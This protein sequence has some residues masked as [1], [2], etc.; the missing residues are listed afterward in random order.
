LSSIDNSASSS[1]G[2]TSTGSTAGISAIPG[3]I[4]HVST[5]SCIR[6]VSCSGS[7]GCCGGR[8]ISS[9]C[10]IASLICANRRSSNSNWSCIRDWIRCSILEGVDGTWGSASCHHREEDP[11]SNSLHSACGQ[12]SIRSPSNSN[13]ARTGS[14]KVEDNVR[15]VIGS[16]V[17]ENEV[18]VKGYH[19]CHIV[20]G[21][22]KAK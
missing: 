17:E 6:A 10:S 16:T 5:I 19:S 13:V 8:G 20:K 12:S 7:R 4:S 3:S 9:C 15:V 21:T 22:C 11:I 1:R 18:L 2:A 14:N